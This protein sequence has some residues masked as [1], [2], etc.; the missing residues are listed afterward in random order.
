MCGAGCSVLWP[1]ATL[2][3]WMLSVLRLENAPPIAKS[4]PSNPPYAKTFPSDPSRIQSINTGARLIHQN[5]NVRVVDCA[6]EMVCALS[7]TDEIFG[8]VF[9]FPPC[10]NPLSEQLRPLV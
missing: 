7:K 4:H 3:C 1:R 2:A 5:Y 8:P 6:Q 10:R 9:S